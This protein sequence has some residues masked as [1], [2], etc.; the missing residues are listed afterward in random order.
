MR[1]QS[2]RTWPT[3]RR[4]KANAL[5]VF[6]PV[7]YEKEKT[8]VERE[9]RKGTQKRY[10]HFRRSLERARTV[11]RGRNKH[12]TERR[13]GKRVSPATCP[14]AQELSSRLTWKQT[15]LENSYEN[16]QQYTRQKY[17][18]RRMSTS[19][20]WSDSGPLQLHSLPPQIPDCF[21]QYEPL[22]L[23]SRSYQYQ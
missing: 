5:R 17:R 12:P 21:F 1:I 11:E 4:R 7:S 8:V 16:K 18:P 2:P 15:Q 10:E 6:P 14:T 19:R 22:E 9:R 20:P 13:G 23:T 3:V